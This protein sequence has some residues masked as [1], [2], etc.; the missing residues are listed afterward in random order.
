[1]AVYSSGPQGGIS[2]N[3]P[4]LDRRTSVTTF[5]SDGVNN[6]VDDNAPHAFPRIVGLQMLIVTRYSGGLPAFTW[7]LELAGGYNA[8][9]NGY[10]G[11]F[12]PSANYIVTSEPLPT[13]SS[14]TYLNAGPTPVFTTNIEVQT[15]DA[16]VGNPTYTLSY[17][18]YALVQPKIILN[19]PFALGADNL[20]VKT[21]YY[22]VAPR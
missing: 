22:R 7:I 10:I 14:I 3:A 20:E 4:I 11:S 6:P 8:N 18:P 17:S 1:M 2:F 16:A 9:S 15:T 13:N 5:Q 21:V 19:A 12:D